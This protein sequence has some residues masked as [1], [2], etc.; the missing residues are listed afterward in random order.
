M[1]AQSLKVHP[2]VVRFSEEDRQS[3]ACLEPRLHLTRHHRVPSLAG[4]WLFFSG[5]IV[6][7]AA[8]VVG[9]G[10]QGAAEG[11][12]EE[13][14]EEAEEAQEEETDNAILKASGAG[15]AYAAGRRFAS[16]FVPAHA[17]VVA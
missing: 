6:G 15:L 7:E 11:A 16:A 8:G 9:E 2:K 3:E 14:E 17:G 5:G 4:A 12:E 1:R 10:L 13:S